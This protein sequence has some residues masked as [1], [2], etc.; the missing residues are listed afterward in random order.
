MSENIAENTTTNEQQ[1]VRNPT[2]DQQ[3]LPDTELKEWLVGYVGT[4]QSPDNGE[5]TVEMIVETMADEFPE[6]LMAVAEENWIRGYYQAM[7]DV[8]EG[9]R[10]IRQQVVQRE[11]QRTEQAENAEPEQE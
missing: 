11:Q 3:V 1:A 6:F 7:V 5:V 2:L 10:A 8:E 9:T 4:Q